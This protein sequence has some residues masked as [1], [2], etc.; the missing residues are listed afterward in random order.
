MV[1][2]SVSTLSDGVVMF[3]AAYISTIGVV[4]V[5]CDIFRFFFHMHTMVNTPA[6]SGE[7]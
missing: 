1:T 5:T 2:V 6:V 4:I 7:F 3:A